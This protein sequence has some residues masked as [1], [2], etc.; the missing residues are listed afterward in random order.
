MVGDRLGLSHLVGGQQ[1]GDAEGGLLGDDLADGGPAVDVDA[2]GRLV[3]EQDPRATD[4][5][6]RQRQALLLAAGEPAPRCGGNRRQ[7]EALEQVRGIE[8]V[9][10]VGSEEGQG[11]GRGHHGVDAT[12][13]EH[14]TDGRHQLCPVG[15][16]IESEDA[17]GSR[18]GGGQALQGLDGR[19]LA[20][21]VGAEQGHDLTVSD[22]E[23]EVI[24]GRQRT[25]ANDEVFDH[26]ARRHPHT[27]RG[28]SR[29]LL[30]L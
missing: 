19:G 27:I 14:D 21:T 25:V 9:V 23:V 22:R 17:D 10:V 11:L 2:G 6:Q 18:G 13:L 4:E 28:F 8:R 16:R 26:D 1:H 20:G 15:D 30:P 7:A 29:P 5:G 12:L 3:E 24:D